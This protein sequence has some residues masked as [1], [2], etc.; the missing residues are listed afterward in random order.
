MDAILNEGAGPCKMHRAVYKGRSAE[1]LPTEALSPGR[2]LLFFKGGYLLSHADESARNATQGIIEVP[3]FRFRQLENN[4]KKRS[5]GF[6]RWNSGKVD[7]EIV[8]N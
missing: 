8:C 3:K 7:M 1:E 2:V 5:Y 6:V 4:A